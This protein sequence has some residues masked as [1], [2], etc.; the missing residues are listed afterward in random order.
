MIDKALAYL[1]KELKHARIALERAERKPNAELEIAN[2]K[3]KI[4]T[5]E[6][7]TDLVGEVSHE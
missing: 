1:R 6:W 7:L 3:R 5:L 2:L 4:E